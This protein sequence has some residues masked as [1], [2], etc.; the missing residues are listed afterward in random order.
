[1]VDQQVKCLPFL[2]FS[3]DVQ[4]VRTPFELPCMSRPDWGDVDPQKND[5]VVVSFSQNK[6]ICEIKN[7]GES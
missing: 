5:F 3:S 1:M 2:P 7:V 4:S 6:F